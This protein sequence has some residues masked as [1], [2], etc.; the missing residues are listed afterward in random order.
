MRERGILFSVPM[1]RALPDG[2]KTQTRR[3]V[4]F[5]HAGEVDAWS[6]DAPSG[7]WRMGVHGD[8]GAF[9]DYGGIRCPYGQPGDRLW[10]RET[11]GLHAY[12]DFTYWNR[13]SI[14][15]RSADDLRGSWELAYAAD[16]ES[17]YDHWR[18]S[19]HMPRWASRITLEVTDVR[20]ERLQDISEEDSKAEGLNGV[21]K[22]GALVKYG[23]PDRDGWPGDD[24]DGW[25]WE[26]WNV[27]PRKA[28]RHL[29]LL[30]N[31]ADSWAANPWVWA[32]SFRRLP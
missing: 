13:D 1:V 4:K 21:T 9:A 12:G 8:G 6:F 19:I 32:I 20:V 7:L 25:P 30:I 15:G 16:A 18:P 27:D 11:W 3:V 17:S 5:E 2:R 14:K 26:H 31:G 29:W 22:D 28:F 24:D 23:I 10:V